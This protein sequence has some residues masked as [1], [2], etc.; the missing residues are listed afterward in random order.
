MCFIFV[1]SNSVSETDTVSQI[2][3]TVSQN[4]VEPRCTATAKFTKTSLY[5][6]LGISDEILA[7]SQ[8]VLTVTKT[9]TL[10]TWLRM[11]AS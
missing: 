10:K 3:R 2:F 4:T 8:N 11:K 7:V 1:A 9:K 5:D 6:H